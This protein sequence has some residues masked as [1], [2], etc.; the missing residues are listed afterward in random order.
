ML[1]GKKKLRSSNLSFKNDVI[2][3]VI[4]LDL[5]L[6]FYSPLILWFP[7]H[8]LLDSKSYVFMASLW[9]VTQ[10]KGVTSDSYI[11]YLSEEI[12]FL[13][14]APASSVYIPYSDKKNKHLPNH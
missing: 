8:M 7:F 6:I 10:M 11:G 2:M 1:S 5:S 3:F 12:P 14:E 13:I 4:K 9:L